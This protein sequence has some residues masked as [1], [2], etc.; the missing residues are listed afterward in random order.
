M[1]NWPVKIIIFQVPAAHH[2]IQGSANLGLKPSQKY[3]L[4]DAGQYVLQWEYFQD[5]QTLGYEN[6]PPNQIYFQQSIADLEPHYDATHVTQPPAAP[7]PLDGAHVDANNSYFWLGVNV[8]CTEYVR[9]FCE[10]VMAIFQNP[11]YCLSQ[12]T[13]PS[14]FE[15]KW[16]IET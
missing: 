9:S 12:K 6:T 4:E 5:E 10:G 14:E 2:Y 7:R 3:R 11:H 13:V 1:A 8:Y 16:S 15:K